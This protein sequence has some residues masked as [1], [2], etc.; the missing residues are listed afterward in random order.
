[1]TLLCTT[2]LWSV[3]VMEYWKNEQPTPIFCDLKRRTV[4]WVEERNPTIDIE[5][6]NPTYN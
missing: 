3:G 6:L 1:M 4:G 5:M 2:Y